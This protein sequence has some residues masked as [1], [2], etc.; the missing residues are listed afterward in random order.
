[1]DLGLTHGAEA[2]LEMEGSVQRLEVELEESIT[3]FSYPYGRQDQMTDANRE[4]ARQMGL[5]CSPS[6]FGGHVEPGDSPYH[7]KRQ[8]ISSWHV[9][10]WQFGFEHLVACIR[11]GNGSAH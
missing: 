11:S 10:P 4:L 3:L 7:L 1:V 2:Q 8:P 9:S 6:A 5:R